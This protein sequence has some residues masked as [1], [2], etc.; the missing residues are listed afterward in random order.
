[1]MADLNF[2]DSVKTEHLKKGVYSIETLVRKSEVQFDM[3]IALERNFVIKSIRMPRDVTE[4]REFSHEA[5]L[6][7]ANG[8]TL[9][10]KTA[11]AYKVGEKIISW[12]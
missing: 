2:I 5:Y 9:C 1:M 12:L 8:E 10:L 11:N 3:S 7:E 4:K 6:Y